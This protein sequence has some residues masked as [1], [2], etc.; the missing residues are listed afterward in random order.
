[1]PIVPANLN[2]RERNLWDETVSFVEAVCPAL[3]IRDVH[4]TAEKIYKKMSFV[5]KLPRE[6]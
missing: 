1:M 2:E 3:D 4:T 5:L 6:K